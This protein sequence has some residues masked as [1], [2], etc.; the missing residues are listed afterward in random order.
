MDH[1]TILSDS[2]VREAWKLFTSKG[3]I[4]REVLRDKIMYSW[5]RARLSGVDFNQNDIC[6]TRIDHPMDN[7]MIDNEIVMKLR[8][9][10]ISCLIIDEQGVIV[11]SYL[12]DTTLGKFDRGLI[13]EENKLGTW[14]YHLACQSETVEEV[15]GCEHYLETYHQI[16]DMTLPVAVSDKKLYMLFMVEMV[17]YT[18]H[19]SFQCKEIGAC[20]LNSI[21]TLKRENTY[22]NS[23]VEGFSERA[24]MVIDLTGKIK[25]VSGN[26]LSERIVEM[27]CHHLFE[28]F[29]MQP[30]M[31]GAS[32]IIYMDHDYA[33]LKLIC[34]PIVRKK[35]N[36]SVVI[37][38]IEAVTSILGLYQG[39]KPIYSLKDLVGDSKAIQEVIRR[40]EKH[41][42]SDRSLLITGDKGTGK[43]VAA[44]CI[45]S[46][47]SRSNKPFL[48]IDCSKIHHARAKSLLFGSE[49]GKDIGLLEM[50]SGGTVY[51]DRANELLQSVQLKLFKVISK[52][53]NINDSFMST[54][55]IMGVTISKESNDMPL[56]DQLSD[57][58]KLTTIEMPQFNK[59]QTDFNQLAKKYLSEVGISEPVMGEQLSLL[60]MS[61][62]SENAHAIRNILNKEVEKQVANHK[63]THQISLMAPK[64]ELDLEDQLFNLDEIEMKTIIKALIA[65]DY[66]MSSAAKLLGVGRT[67]LY[68]KIDKYNIM[69]DEVR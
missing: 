46:L 23:E 38:G 45:H 19:F 29:S 61:N 20:W 66:N 11:T 26:L 51:L 54:R 17:D 47:S 41:A 56:I 37:M 49:D 3:M 28:H 69:L 14:S 18:K 52:D 57:Q 48:W 25:S 58:L 21:R 22:E 50:A 42:L 13:F 43:K 12:C 34:M 44:N 65:T 7:L 62:I 53:K 59:R 15:I 31:S 2:Q 24:E 67:T 30:V 55:I 36:F 1:L 27:N 33:K 16:A 60:N 5:A 10:N 64:I 8:K 32:Q 40:I 39:F 9:E 35:Q 63:S 6:L 68:R 4:K